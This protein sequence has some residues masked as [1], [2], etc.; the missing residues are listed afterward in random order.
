[1]KKIPYETK[2]KTLHLVQFSDCWADEFDVE[3]FCV[4]SNEEIAD[5]KQRFEEIFDKY[6]E[7]EYS[8]G[9]NEGIDYKNIDDLMRNFVFIPIDEVSANLL[10]GCFTSTYYGGEG[11]A[12]KEIVMFGKFPMIDDDQ[13]EDMKDIYEL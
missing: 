12:D 7:Y 2:G 1:M 9:T 10:K 5:W 4:M 3:G 8:F 13:Y 11:K 6:G